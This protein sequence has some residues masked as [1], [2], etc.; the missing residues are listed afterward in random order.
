MGQDGL[1]VNLKRLR[2]YKRLT[3]AEVAGKAG[4]SVQAFRNLE[5]GRSQPR[6]RT[7][8]ALAEALEVRIAELLSPPGKLQAVRFRAKKKLRA[9]DHILVRLAKWLEDFT[10]LERLAGSPSRA[11]LPR[12]SADWGEGSQRGPEA[13]REV[14]RGFGL[15]Q[16]DTIR[17]ICGLLEDNGIKV[18][19]LPVASDAFFGL[20]VADEDGGPAIVVNVW[21]RISVERWIFTAAHEL[22]HLVLHHDAFEVQKTEEDQKEEKQANIF[23]AHFLMPAE[24]FLREWSKSAGMR[25]VDRVLWVKRL[26]SVSY[27]TVLYRLHEL[28]SMPN[29]RAR[30]YYEFERH[31]GKKL[32]K[33]EE[34]Q[35]LPPESFLAPEARKAKEPQTLKDVDFSEK[36]FA[37]LVREVLLDGHI[38]L[39]RASEILGLDLPSMRE[40]AASWAAEKEPTF[41]RPAC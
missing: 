41:G 9:R 18:F 5:A 6:V 11:K 14:R 32:R 2:L 20:S 4:I 10:E 22:G 37:R 38:S 39:G 19:T 35:A 13:A 8:E 16:E 27:K 28:G 7:L 1:A 21:D 33:A 36:G 31:Y 23:A 34:P 12:I 29:I 40:L 25:L 17:D 3:Q 30:F 24:A 15:S 26:F